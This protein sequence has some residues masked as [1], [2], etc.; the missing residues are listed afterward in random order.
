MLTDRRGEDAPVAVPLGVGVSVST[1]WSAGEADTVLV[2][3]V[4]PLGVA[5][6]VAAVRHGGGAGRPGTIKST[7]AAPLDVG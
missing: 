5:V 7:W 4:D 6:G 1:G 2:A 3:V